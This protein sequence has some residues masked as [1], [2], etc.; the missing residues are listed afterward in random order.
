MKIKMCI[1][2][3]CQVLVTLIRTVVMSVADE[4]FRFVYILDHY[5]YGIRT[6]RQSF[7]LT[8]LVYSNYISYL[9]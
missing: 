2:I 5:N 9:Y 8:P 6:H 7:Q 1:Y 4:L 3:L